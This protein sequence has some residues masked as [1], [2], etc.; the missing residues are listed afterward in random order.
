MKLK[1]QVAASQ[2]RTPHFRAQRVEVSPASA[3]FRPSQSLRKQ[4]KQRDPFAR[5]RLLSKYV[6]TYSHTNNSGDKTFTPWLDIN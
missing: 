2:A 5:K 4:M 6:S 3:V 1:G